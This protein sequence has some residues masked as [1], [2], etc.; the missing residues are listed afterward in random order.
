[1]K[2][3]LEVCVLTF[4]LNIYEH[5]FQLPHSYQQLLSAEKTPTLYGT[6][7]AFEKLLFKLRKLQN[8]AELEF[9]DIIQDGIEKLEEYQQETE[10]V[11]AYK[12]AISK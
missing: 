1:M 10:S 7:P 11:P 6:L 5:F 8:E 9:N 4:D 2:D 3:I 12:L